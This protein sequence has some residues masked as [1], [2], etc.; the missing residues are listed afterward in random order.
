VTEYLSALERE[1]ESIVEP[2]A[3]PYREFWTMLRY[4]LGWTNDRGDSARSDTGKRLRPL[5][6]LWS[7]QAVGGDWRDALA[8]ACAIE[9]IHNFSLIHDDIEDNSETRRG[10]P[11]IWKRWGIAQAVNSGDAM[12]V[13]AHLS[14]D[15]LRAGISVS[16]YHK[17]HETFDAATLRLTQGQFLDLTYERADRVTLDQYLEM[18]RGKTAALI[19]AACEIGARVST[20]DEGIARA[21]ARYGE[22]LGIAYQITDDILGLWGDPA[23]TGKSARADLY[24]R[25]KSYPVLAAMQD[26]TSGELRGLY[27]RAVWQS[28]DVERIE[29]IIAECR[30]REKAMQVAEGYARKAARDLELT[31]CSNEMA[32][33]LHAVLNQAVHREK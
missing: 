19:S 3:A 25:K 31:G 29:Q 27:A 23:L 14:L 2:G 1:L 9:L 16:R 5:L 4:H 28:G 8:P 33:H 6:C 18:V 30:S 7:C 26:D 12:F 17:I 32:A 24:S 15:R 13:L 11:T 10:R 21:F 20:E 22:N